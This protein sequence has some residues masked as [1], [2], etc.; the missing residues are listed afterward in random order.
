[1]S[2]A[3][4]HHYGPATRAVRAGREPTPEQEHSEPLFLTSSFTYRSAAEA[5]AR[6]SGEA[7]GNIYSRFTNPTVQAFE[8]RL[9]ALEGCERC[10]GTSSGMSAI[11]VACMGLLRA[12]GHIVSSKGVF[13][14]TVGLFENY[15]ARFNIETTFVPLTDYDAWAAA[16]NERTRLLFLETPSNP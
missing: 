11:L 8:R 12:G 10:I 5:A 1:M 13:G 15:L 7:P 16:I 6:F 3:E 9:A 2:D 14:T 4:P